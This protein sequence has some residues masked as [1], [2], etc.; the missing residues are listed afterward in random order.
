MRAA[1]RRCASAGARRRAGATRSASL[2]TWGDGTDGQLGHT[3]V[4][5]SGLMN[6]YVELLPRSLAPMAGAPVRSL[7]GGLNHTLCVDGDGALWAWGK[8]DCGKLGTG[9]G[10]K[11]SEAPARVAALEGVPLAAVACGDFHSAALDEQGRVYTWGWGGSYFGGY[12]MLG[13]GGTDEHKTPKLV[14]SLVAEGCAIRAVSC[15]EA[16]TLLLTDDDE[17]LVCGAGEYGRLGT[18]STNDLL[19]PEPVTFL[20]EVEVAEAWAGS[21]FNIA[22]E[23]GGEVWVWG[24]N[25]Q[26]QLGLG[27]SLS[28]D[29]YSMEPVPQLL[30]GID[31]VVKTV[32]AGHSHAA[33]ITEDGALYHWGMKLY[34]EPQKM[35]FPDPDE[36]AAAVV[37]GH[38]FSLVQTESGRVYSF[39]VGRT[40]CLGHGDKKKVMSPQPIQA[41]SDFRVSAMF[42]GYH[43][44]AVAIDEDAAVG[45]PAA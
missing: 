42:A 18:G 12:G 36:R 25:D 40:C 3:P 38:N 37:C 10:E 31:G 41:L 27:G 44:V 14:E 4:A 20:A 8:G 1:V 13:H 2:L 7:A 45:E 30:T 29:V 32:A 17:L 16:H 26:G 5:R 21:A 43:H 34:L 28:M 39:G 6:S 15:G 23:R 9:K 22:L 24:R 19:V 11:S 33:A 35:V